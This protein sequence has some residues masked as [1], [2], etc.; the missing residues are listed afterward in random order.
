MQFIAQMAGLGATRLV[1]RILVLGL[2]DGTRTNVLICT[3]SPCA[4]VFAYT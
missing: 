2:K 4:I 3:V 1:V